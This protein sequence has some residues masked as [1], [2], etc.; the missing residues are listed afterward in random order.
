MQVSY[1]RKCNSTFVRKGKFDVEEVEVNNED[2]L[3]DTIL[4]ALEEYDDEN[5]DNIAIITKD[6]E[7]LKKIAPEL[8][9][10]Y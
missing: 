3:I 1:Q 4:E 5:Y 8:K 6:K 7:D 10:V 9:K 2:D